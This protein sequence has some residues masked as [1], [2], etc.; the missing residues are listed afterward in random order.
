[1]TEATAVT[2]AK[3]I[4]GTEASRRLGVTQHLLMKM[5]VTG[6]L[7]ATALPGRPLRFD[8]VEVDALARK[9]GRFFLP[10]G[11]PGPGSAA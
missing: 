2:Q 10:P 7:T 5:A 3:T 9:L 11:S 1:M 8:P 4:S 6:E